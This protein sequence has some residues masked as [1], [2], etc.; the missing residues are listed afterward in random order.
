MGQVKNPF[1]SNRWKGRN[2]PF[3]LVGVALLVIATFSRVRR[4]SV[5]NNEISTL[6]SKSGSPGPAFLSGNVFVH[7]EVIDG[8]DVLWASPKENGGNE[9]K[10]LVFLAHGCSHSNLDWFAKKSPE[11]ET[12]IGLPEEQAIVKMALDMGLVAIAMSAT[13]PTSHCWSDFDVTPVALVLNE[14]WHRFSKAQAATKPTKPEKQQQ[15]QNL[16]SNG[17]PLYAF[18]ASSGGKFVT[19]LSNPL[20]SR[21]GIRL[22]GFVSQISA[23][24]P[25]LRNDHDHPS[26]CKV[27]VTMNKDEHTDRKAKAR[28]GK[29]EKDLAIINN[30]NSTK[31]LCKQIRLPSIPIT[32]SFFSD[33][34][35]EISVAESEEMAKVLREAM[36]LD[37]VTGELREDP[38][39]NGEKWRDALRLASLSGTS[40]LQ[41]TKRGD[42]LIPDKSPISEVMNVAWGFHEMTRD[43]V[44]EAL[45][46]CVGQP[47]TR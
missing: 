14:L 11:C 44:K 2:S 20:Y 21:F 15:E 32:P 7:R 30:N 10:G 35:L 4:L 26:L 1:K 43:G 13:N 24:L 18:G 19:T 36:L 8:R 45:E 23:H 38:R 46:F 22:N 29:C 37:E 40:L 12:C 42:E 5:G 39:K 25:L 17:L 28:V 16:N 27:Y 47:S 6:A 3:I 31:P 33:R 34:I 9:I 41:F